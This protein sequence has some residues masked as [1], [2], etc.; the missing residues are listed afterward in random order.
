MNNKVSPGQE[1]DIKELLYGVAKAWRPVIGTGL[2]CAVLLGGYKA[3]QTL[4]GQMDPEYA[5]EQQEEYEDDLSVYESAK[6]SYE[7]EIDNIVSSLDSQ[8][9]YLQ[10]S[11]LMKISPYDKGIASAQLYIKTDYEIM[12]SMVYQNADY[13]DALVRAYASALKE[14]EILESAAGSMGTEPR[15]LKEL[16]TVEEDLDSNVV[17]VTVAHESEEEAEALLALLLQGIEEKEEELSQSVGE[18]QVIVLS[19]VTDSVV[20]LTLS[21]SQKRVT[22]TLS[23]LQDS[24]EEKKQALNALSEPSLSPI[25]SGA[26]VSQGIKYGVL[27]GI[28][29]VLLGGFVSCLAFLMGDKVR[30][31]RQVELRFGLRPLG[32]FG[33]QRKR[34]F[35]FADRMI[36]RL[37]GKKALPEAEREYQ[38]MGTRLRYYYPEEKE[39]LVAG[40]AGENHSSQLAKRLKQEF[41]DR[42]I[43]DGG[44]LSEDPK[45]LEAAGKITN[46]GLILAVERGRTS[47]QE[48]SREM[49]T[50]ADCGLQILGFVLMPEH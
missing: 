8:Q 22:D 50:A 2:V 27:G 46:G 23:T 4:A 33:D 43:Q 24:L 3:S 41:P 12:P 44:A 10:K 11:I 21:D 13:T 17:Q 14:D 7:R 39:L 16:I 26:S 15:Y 18:N 48:I 45:A 28:M 36:D 38:L 35:S 37:F 29:G 5:R 30:D 40:P 32:V 47:Y 19:R 1:V 6:E 49:E 20:D 34:W 9:E 42:R 31:E 25:S